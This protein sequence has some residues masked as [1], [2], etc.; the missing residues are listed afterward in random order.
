MRLP[1]PIIV[2]GLL[3]SSVFVVGCFKRAP[4]MSTRVTTPI[5]FSSN[6]IVGI[7]QSTAPVVS[8]VVSSSSVPVFNVAFDKIT[9]VI[10]FEPK[11]NVS[12]NIPIPI[13]NFWLFALSLLG[14]QF[15]LTLLVT[16]LIYLLTAPWRK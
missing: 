2:G 7:Q 1:L 14:V 4:S 6:S 16:A 3:I 12:V 9:P 5:D 15:I 11:I 13:K 10:K 8:F